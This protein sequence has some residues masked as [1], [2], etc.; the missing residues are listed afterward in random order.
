MYHYTK[1]D[2]AV[3]RVAVGV[4]VAL[5]L[6]LLVL[7]L[8]VAVD[9]VV[10]V[11][12][13]VLF[14]FLLLLLLLFLLGQVD[15]SPRSLSF[16]S[17]HAHHSQAQWMSLLPE[18]AFDEQ[19]CLLG[20]WSATSSQNHLC[21][22]TVNTT[23]TTRNPT[24]ASYLS[25][26]SSFLI[27]TVLT[28]EYCHQHVWGWQRFVLP[29]SA[30]ASV[31]HPSFP[32]GSPQGSNIC[33]NTTSP[34]YPWTNMLLPLQGNGASLY[35]QHVDRALRSFL[36]F[37]ALLTHI[38]S[39]WGATH[40]IGYGKLTR[41]GSSRPIL[42]DLKCNDISKHL[43]GTFKPWPGWL[44]RIIIPYVS[45]FAFPWPIPPTLNSAKSQDHFDWNLRWK[46]RRSF[47]EVK[48]QSQLVRLNLQ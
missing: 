20:A 19:R 34:T 13:L 17:F 44:A 35:S 9:V 5:V 16:G 28:Q 18:H 25:D 46:F 1:V 6:F 21:V 14:L 31:Q 39:I 2:V 26:L 22:S 24:N 11:V 7:L 12:V 48:G 41:L 10:V 29:W 3:V 4:V 47:A 38:Y 23:Y 8:C 27:S 36:S 15:P 32:R 37:S 42:T 30:D 45:P 40:K 43:A 33:K